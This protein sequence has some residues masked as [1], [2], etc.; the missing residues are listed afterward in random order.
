M[1]K[2]KKTLISIVLFIILISIYKIINK[3]YN[4]GIPCIFH[5]ITNLYCPGCG[6]T[7]ALFAIMDLDIKTA[8]HCNLLIFILFPFLLIYM[9]NYIYISIKNIN[10][11]PSKIINK[12]T[13]YLLLFITVLFGILRNIDYFY[14]L[15]PI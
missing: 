15:Q 9:I 13:W 1:K 7:R 14:W 3:K 8:M 2:L 10:K 11:D 5:E 4:I 6:I 12:K